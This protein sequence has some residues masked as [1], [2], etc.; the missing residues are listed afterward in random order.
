M[1]TSD[2]RDIRG[3]LIE[4][5]AALAVLAVIANREPGIVQDA[6]TTCS[7]MPGV[8]DIASVVL[9]EPAA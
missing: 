4:Y 3:L 2:L 5:A 1:K 6:V 7:N 8:S 9:T